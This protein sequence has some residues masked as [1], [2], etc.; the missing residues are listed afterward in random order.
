MTTPAEAESAITENLPRTAA[1]RVPLAAAHG[2]IMAETAHAE[3]D[4][5]PFDRVTMDGIAIRYTELAAGRR[6]FKVAG[7]QAAGA[8]ALRLPTSHDCI[9]IM[10]GA[11]LPPGADTIVPVERLA[12]EAGTAVIREEAQIEAGQFVHRQG[13]DRRAGDTVI[14]PGTVLGPAEIAVLASAGYAQVQVA[15]R[16][17]IA[18]I[19]TGDEL[20]GLEDPVEPYQIRSSNDFAIAAALERHS[21]AD[22]S[23]HRLLDDEAAL[24]ESVRRL[25]A[26]NDALI[27]SGGVSMGQFDFVPAVLQ[28]LGCEPVFHRIE[29]KPGRPMWFGTSRDG[30]PIFALPGNPVSTLLCIVRYVVPAFR[31]AAGCTGSG[32][33]EYRLSRA[34]RG[35]RRLTY[36]VPVKIESAGDGQRVANPHPTNTS[37]DFATLAGT[38]GFL[39]LPPGQDEHPA[40]AL[41]RLYRW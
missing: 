41:G 33:A 9:E 12:V 26:K 1:E 35:P 7:T 34:V 40:G 27:L 5:P 17:Q 38:D 14:K 37:G 19:S 3:R 10:T 20:V 2:R 6:S 32:P 8:P 11:V 18:V 29:Q 24:L 22:V 23:R 39:E 36:F 21:L 30:K 31:R 25:H 13:S 28:A 4:Q 16:L 15:R